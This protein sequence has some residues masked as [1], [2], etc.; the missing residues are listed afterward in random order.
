VRNLNSG[1]APLFSTSPQDLSTKLS[2]E[3][4]PGNAL[5]SQPGVTDCALGSWVSFGGL[6]LG[7]A[8]VSSEEVLRGAGLTVLVV[9]DE[10][11]IRYL[12]AVVLEAAG[13]QVIE[14]AHGEAA[15]ERVRSSRPRLV[16]TDRMMPR[17]GGI[18]LIE[19]LRADEDTAGI[20]IVMLTAAPGGEPGADAVLMKPFAQEELVELVDRLTGR[21]S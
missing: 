3:R 16:I 2:T 1:P 6:G 19:Q 4:W 15:L 21:A 10:P 8:G 12:L 17:M 14:A 18:E 11:H 13:Y 5:L 7:G 20:P 9:D